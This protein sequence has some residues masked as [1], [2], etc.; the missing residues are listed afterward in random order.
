MIGVVWGLLGAGLI[1]VSDCI[2]RVTARRVSLALL[3]GAIFGAGFLALLGWFA[4]TGAWP[5]WH[6]YGWAVAAGS[7]LLNLVALALLFLA[8]ARGPV[9]VAS[10]AAS[11]FTILLVGINALAGHAFSWAQVLAAGIVFAGIFMLSRPGRAPVTGEAHDASWLRVTALLGL[12]AALAVSLRMFFAQEASDALGPVETVFLT[13]GFA[14]AGVVAWIG[15]ELARRRPQRW[16][17]RATWPLVLMQGALEIAALGA[18][19]FGSAGTGRVGAAIGFSAFPAV[20]AIA[21]WLWLR[22]PVGARRAFWMA[23]VAGGIV[24]AVLGRPGG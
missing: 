11:S 1:G 14:V 22:E 8:L 7:G 5:A 12:G 18:F 4:A 13:R 9:T 3:M 17:D 10:P 21:A 2:A 24:L 16:P 19:L 20:T 23:V 15:W 6:P